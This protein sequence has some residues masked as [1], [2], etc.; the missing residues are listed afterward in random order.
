MFVVIDRYGLLRG[1][2]RAAGP[3]VPSVTVGGSERGHP[4]LYQVPDTVTSSRPFRFDIKKTPAITT[5]MTNYTAT[6]HLVNTALTR[7]IPRSVK[8]R[9]MHYSTICMIYLTALIL[10][11]VPSRVTPTIVEA[12]PRLSGEEQQNEDDNLAAFVSS[13]EHGP[14]KN[15]HHHQQQHNSQHIQTPEEL[16]AFVSDHIHA[17]PTKNTPQNLQQQQT[18][19]QQ[20]QR[21]WGTAAAKNSPT[22][23]FTDASAGG[24]G[25]SSTNESLVPEGIATS[26]TTG[27]PFVPPKV[28]V[29]A[30]PLASSSSSSSSDIPVLHAPPEGFVVTARVY[31]DPVDKLSHFDSVPT[32]IVLPFF[33]CGAMGLSTNA[34]PLSHASFRHAL[35]G[36]QVWSGDFFTSSE[37]EPPPQQQHQQQTRKRRRRSPSFSS[38][39]S[40]PSRMLVEED[41][42]QDW[43]PQLVV[44][45]TEL[46]IVLNSG[47]NKLFHRGDVILLEDTVLG[48]HK[49]RAITTTPG[50]GSTTNSNSQLPNDMTVLILTLPHYYHQIGKDQHSLQGFTTTLTAPPCPIDDD[51]LTKDP[52]KLVKPD[53]TPL[54]N[55]SSDTS[56]LGRLSATFAIPQSAFVRRPRKKQV[57]QVVLGM[58]GISIS[59]LL[60]DFLGKVAPLW[61]AV[62]IGGTCFVV[63]GTYGIVTTGM[64]ALEYLDMTWER[65]RLLAS[66]TV[67]TTPTVA[68]TTADA[69]TSEAI[70]ETAASTVSSAAAP[71]DRPE[72][73]P[74]PLDPPFYER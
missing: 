30:S 9:R 56:P 17:A 14:T 1:P 18:I 57:Q 20:Q 67:T 43:H 12:T 35:A 40:S 61:L 46:E 4:L 3:R 26:T 6:N 68:S 45:L 32:N 54:D 71:S 47:E 7:S 10:A 31:T 58:I 8:Q 5:T 11:V 44:A 39:S 50:T 64:Q 33:E 53:E 74:K 28:V 16:A 52:M 55:K 60:A 29:T 59:T 15:I 21:R 19:A 73:H 62:G 38:S 42:R 41:E 23:A 72:P 49:L 22:T 25:G 27:L 66:I 70:P 13:S 51:D 65:Q 69:T 48:G 24:V 34:L 37:E 2:Q 63:G 36:S